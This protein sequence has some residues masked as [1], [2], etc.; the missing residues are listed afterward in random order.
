[1]FGPIKTVGV[2][3]EDQGRATDFY[4][5]KLGFEIRRRMPMGPGTAWIEVAPPGT[6]TC[7]VIYPRAMMKDW[8]EKKP[9]IVFHCPDVDATITRLRERGVKVAMEPSD[10]PWGKF[11]AIEDFDG[12]QLGLTEQRVALKPE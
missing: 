8:D 11:A 4:T 3:V 6:E 10:M 7:L 1:M 9:S 12:N 2:Y 5:A